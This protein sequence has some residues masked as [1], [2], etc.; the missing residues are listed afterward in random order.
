MEANCSFRQ[1]CLK[2]LNG[3]EISRGDKSHIYIEGYGLKANTMSGLS[4]ENL[5]L[6]KLEIHGSSGILLDYSLF[7]PYP[8]YSRLTSW[9]HL[10]NKE[11]PKV[12]S[13]K[14]SR[15]GVV[16]DSEIG[17]HNDKKLLIAKYDI[18]CD[19]HCLDFTYTTGG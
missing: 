8:L 13:V 19:T 3:L 1:K 2:K 16:H 6:Q 10:W 11:W 15:I 18:L 5:T 9:S 17:K 7:G 12:V 4:A 14:F